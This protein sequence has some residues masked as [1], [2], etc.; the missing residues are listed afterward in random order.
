MVSRLG[1]TRTLIVICGVGAL[2][3]LLSAGVVIAQ[4]QRSAQGQGMPGGAAMQGMGQMGRGMGPMGLGAGRMMRGRGAMVPGIAL[5][6]LGVT[7]EQRQA[8]RKIVES[9]GSEVQAIQEQAIPARRASDDAIGRTTRLPS[10][11]PARSSARS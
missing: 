4:V 5:G 9:H 7:A 11:T 6:Q 3:A 10:G 8:I 2:V 1:R